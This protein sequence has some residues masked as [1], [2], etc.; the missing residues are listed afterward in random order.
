M[1]NIP[2]KIIDIMRAIIINKDDKRYNIFLQNNK[3][4]YNNKSLCMH[5]FPICSFAE[6][7]VIM[8]LIFYVVLCVYYMYYDMY[9]ICIMY[10]MIYIFHFFLK[11]EIY[12]IYIIYIIIFCIIYINYKKMTREILSKIADPLNIIKLLINFS[13]LR[14]QD[15]VY[16]CDLATTYYDIFISNENFTENEKKFIDFYECHEEYNDFYRKNMHFSRFIKIRQMMTMDYFICMSKKI[17]MT[18]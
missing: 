9:I 7:R 12:I 1:K 6:C 15:K 5:F 11:N 8:K 2:I 18:L 14:Y 3:N 13:S 17:Y 10:I 16:I 4:E